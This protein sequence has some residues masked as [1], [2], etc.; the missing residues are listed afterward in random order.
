MPGRG[1]RS[2]IITVAVGFLVGLVISGVIGD[3][4]GFV[5]ARTAKIALMYSIKSAEWMIAA[6]RNG[7]ALARL[8]AAL[9]RVRKEREPRVYARIQNGLGSA[10]I[11]IAASEDTAANLERAVRAFQE[12]LDVYTI[13]RYRENYAATQNNLGIAYAE[14]ARVKD[15][16]K[17]TRKALQAYGEALGVYTMDRY[18]AEHRQVRGRKAAL[19]RS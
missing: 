7:E 18:P 13:D 5:R 6:D 2:K 16:A 3:A 12:A 10:W 1:E 11:G 15:R 19:E 4:Y 9:P 14:L 17:N 8:Q